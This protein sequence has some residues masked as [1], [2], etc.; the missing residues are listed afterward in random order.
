MKN[1]YIYYQ[2]KKR[3][4]INSNEISEYDVRILK[5]KLIELENDNKKTKTNTNRDKNNQRIIKLLLNTDF[6]GC[7]FEKYIDIFLFL[8]NHKPL[9]EKEKTFKYYLNGIETGLITEFA[10][11]ME[12]IAKK[13]DGP[14]IKILDTSGRTDLYF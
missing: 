14:S 13:N 4:L 11:K 12:L 10:N 8:I 9:T 6:N 7:L 1:L 3:I 2:R 5:I